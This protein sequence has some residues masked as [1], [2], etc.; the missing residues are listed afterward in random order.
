LTK[1]YA[2]RI[3]FDVPTNTRSFFIAMHVAL[4]DAYRFLQICYKSFGSETTDCVK[5]ASLD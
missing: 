5:A 4:T 2:K 3:P 1:L